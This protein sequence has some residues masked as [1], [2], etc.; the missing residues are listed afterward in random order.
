[1]SEDLLE[2]IQ[3]II[4]KSAFVPQA[5]LNLRR[6]ADIY[7]DNQRRRVF[8]D[9]N[10][11]PIEVD[12]SLFS[13]EAVSEQSESHGNPFDDEALSQLRPTDQQE[14]TLK[15]AN[16]VAQAKATRQRTP[17]TRRLENV[18]RGHMLTIDDAEEQLEKDIDGLQYV[19]V[20]SPMTSATHKWARNG[21][22]DVLNCY[23]C[24]HGVGIQRVE[25]SLIE[26]LRQLIMDVYTPGQENIACGLIEGWFEEHIRQPANK[27]LQT[28]MQEIG[29]WP[30]EKIYQHIEW[31]MDEPTFLK[32][33][34]MSDA[35]EYY[36]MIY[37]REVYR[38]PVDRAYPGSKITPADYRMTLRGDQLYD[39]ALKRL[40]TIAKWDPTTAPNFNPKLNL[41][42]SAKSVIA[43]KARP[44]DYTKVASIF[45]DVDNGVC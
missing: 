34:L 38:V 42:Q 35:K 26:Q 30:A 4:S 44:L 8:H 21:P 5:I 28:G 39:R 32:R 31:H 37:L 3:P 2:D 15:A 24:S 36:R 16:I 43:Q 13:S 22:I 25:H 1:M 19:P 40:L 18:M 12:D 10:G 33:R 41:A 45:T 23:G 6:S 27:R 14:R 17:G 20:V 11:V 7:F 29:P 9:A